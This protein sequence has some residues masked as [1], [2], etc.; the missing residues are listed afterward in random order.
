MMKIRFLKIAQF[1]LDDTVEYYNV[2]SPGLGYRFLREVFAAIDRIKE[3]PEA[4]QPFHMGT[5]RCL[6][7]RFPYGVIYKHIDELILIVA[8]ANLHRKPDYWINR[9][10]AKRP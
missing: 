9:L 4:W 7:R 3:F 10:I 2:E 6:V 1:E 8:I 5:R